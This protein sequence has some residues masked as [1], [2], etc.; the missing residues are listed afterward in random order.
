MDYAAGGVGGALADEVRA[1][2][3]DNGDNKKLRIVLCGHAGEHDELLSH[4]WTTRTW[5]ARRGYAATSEAV[6]N[7]A[8]ETLWVSPAC[9]GAPG[10]EAPLVDL[11]TGEVLAAPLSAHD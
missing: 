1:W 2:C 5:K 10:V 7:R 8:S 3:R 4:G 6:E 9:V 11:F